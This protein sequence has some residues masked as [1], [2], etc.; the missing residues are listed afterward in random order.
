MHAL[1]HAADT[2]LDEETGDI[3]LVADHLRHASLDTARGYAKR[4]NAKVVKAVGRW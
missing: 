1:R 2:R 4:N 3:V